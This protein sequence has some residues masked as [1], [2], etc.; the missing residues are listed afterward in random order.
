M[1][2]NSK[3]FGQPKALCSSDTSPKTSFFADT[4]KG[5]PAPFVFLAHSFTP[6]LTSSE[7]P[8]SA[9]DGYAEDNAYAT[10]GRQLDDIQ[11]VDDRPGWNV[12]IPIKLCAPR[13][14]HRLGNNNPSP[15][16][17]TIQQYLTD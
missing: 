9:Q 11:H 8:A 7:F 1:P 16:L 10:W 13:F 12:C 2:S 6:L 3:M 5:G 4:R 17:T 15:G 14:A